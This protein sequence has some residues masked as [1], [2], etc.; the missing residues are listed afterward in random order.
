MECKFLKF[1]DNK[2]RKKIEPIILDQ[3]LKETQKITRISSLFVQYIYL[4]KHISQSFIRQ[5][6][7]YLDSYY[8]VQNDQTD[9]N[10]IRQY[11]DRLRSYD[12]ITYLKENKNIDINFFEQF[13]NEINWS[14]VSQ[15]P[16]RYNLDFL[17]KY[18]DKISWYFLSK[19]YNITQEF[20]Q[21][22]Q[23]QDLDWQYITDAMDLTEQF[24]QKYQSKLNMKQIV[25]DKQFEFSNQFKKKYPLYF[26]KRAL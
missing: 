17:Q 4:G 8:L 11:R 10:V 9:I 6:S 2:L 1:S 26:L 18:K 3:K 22:F 12:F 23:N 14:E 24:I 21:R 19:W 15:I 13:A 7:P 16:F 5:I 25:C 20:I